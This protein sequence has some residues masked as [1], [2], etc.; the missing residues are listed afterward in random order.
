[1]STSAKIAT[2]HSSTMTTPPAIASRFRMSRRTPSRHRLVPRAAGRSTFEAGL[3]PAHPSEGEASEGAVEAPAD[4]DEGRSP[5]PGLIP[6]PGVERAIGEVDD[7]VHHR[8]EH[9][10]GE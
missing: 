6:D 10:V 2:R 1:M 9:A 8:Q 4:R 7:E 5:P 3:C